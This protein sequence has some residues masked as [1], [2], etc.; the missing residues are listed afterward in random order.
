M[1]HY[2]QKDGITIYHGSCM[3]IM[4]QLD[5]VDAVVT[6]PPYGVGVA[7]NEFDDSQRNLIDLVSDAIPE[8]RRVAKRVALTP[9]QSNLWHYPPADWV[10]AWVYMTGTNQSKWGF[11]VWQPILVYGPCPYREANLGA[12]PD[13]IKITDGFNKSS[14]VDHPCPKPPKCWRKII[15]RVTLSGTILDPFLGSGT[16]LVVAKQLGRDAIGIELD[17]KYCE[18]AAN[19]LESYDSSITM[20]DTMR[21]QQGLFNN[22]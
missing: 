8:C 7:Y 21:G 15:E 13:V 22:D 9:G 10:L 12:R 2:Y 4:P 3:D 19:R 14:V 18:V 17:E 6:D 1:K 5:D 11:T 20:S 16:T